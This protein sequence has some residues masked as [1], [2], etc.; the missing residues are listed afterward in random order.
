MPDKLDGPVDRY[1][2]FDGYFCRGGELEPMSGR[3]RTVHHVCVAGADDEER[4]VA[5]LDPLPPDLSARLYRPCRIVLEFDRPHVASVDGKP[6]AYD[7]NGRP[8]GPLAPLSIQTAAVDARVRIVNLIDSLRNDATPN[9]TQT[10][11]C[12]SDI[13]GILNDALNGI[14]LDVPAPAAKD[15]VREVRAEALELMNKLRMWR[16]ANVAPNSKPID[17]II[18]GLNMAIEKLP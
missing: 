8:L 1:V 3:S 6:F 17:V 10:V 14:A 13:Y 7:I 16:G 18:G 9:H 2:A 11:E 15:R 12:L 4:S 5:F